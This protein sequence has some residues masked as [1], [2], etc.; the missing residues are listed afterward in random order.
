MILFDAML[1]VARRVRA[2][3]TGSATGGT[4]NTLIDTLFRSEADD[5]FNGQTV[6]VLSGNNE[7][8][9]RTI[10]DFVSSTHTVTV[11]TAWSN[12]IIAGV[13]YAIT[14]A[15]REDLVQAINAALEEIGEY[16]QVDTSLVVVDNQTEYTLP[17]GVHNVVRVEVAVSTSADYDYIKVFDWSEINGYLYFDG[18]MNFAA[19][20]TIRIFYNAIHEAVD[21]DTDTVSEDIPLPMIA[22]LAAY[23]YFWQQFV[24][25]KNLGV[26]DEALMA[27]AENDRANALTRYTVNKIHRDPKHG[28]SL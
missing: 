9:T 5:D 25:N 20:R 11:G 19:G 2:M 14:E 15:R 22:G 1:A 28:G 24:N 12:A 27:K 10:T 17:A 21:A 26:K 4:T 18:E 16:T 3:Y 8:T 23:H 6:F 7:K 13:R